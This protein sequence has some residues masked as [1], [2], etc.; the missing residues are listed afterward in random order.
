M[1][2]HPIFKWKCPSCRSCSC[3]NWLGRLRRGL[4]RWNLNFS[5]WLW[6][7]RLNLWTLLCS[8]RHFLL[9]RCCLEW[10]L[11]F[12]L[13]L[14]IWFAS[15]LQISWWFFCNK[16]LWSLFFCF[17]LRGELRCQDIRVSLS[18]RTLFWDSHLLLRRL[19]LFRWRRSHL[20][21]GQSSLLWW[22]MNLH[23]FRIFNLSF[24]N[25]TSIWFHP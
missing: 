2:W 17:V 18:H 13:P 21:C 1:H 15:F 12:V 4:L 24:S 20:I 8:F 6:G 3:I 7:V 25:V 14:F 9:L 22:W 23:F 10:I 5:W 19:K 11:L 16:L